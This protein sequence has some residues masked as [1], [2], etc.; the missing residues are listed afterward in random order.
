VSR[1]TP[2]SGANG[3][4]TGGRATDRSTWTALAIVYIAWGSTYV[5]IRVMDRTTPPLIGGAIRFLAAGALMFGFVVLRRRRLPRVSGRELASL[6]LVGVLLLSGGNGLVTL[7]E[8]RVPAGLAALLV[9]SMPLW[10]LVLRTLTGD[11]PRRATLV[12]LAIGFCGVGLLVLRGGRGHGV[13][14]VQMLVVVGAALSWATGSFLSSKLPL[15]ADVA[16]GTAIE[17]MIGGAV[18]A[19][20]G[21]LVGEHWQALS[22]QVSADAWIA[23][24]YLAL[25]GSI[26][27]F[28]A[29]VWLLQNAPISKISTYAY[30]NPVVAVVL[31]AVILGEAITPFMVLGGVVI[32]TAVAVVIGSESRPDPPAPAAASVELPNAGPAL[33]ETRRQRTPAVAGWR[34]PRGPVG[35]LSGSGVEHAADELGA[36][37]GD[38]H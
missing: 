8:R 18:L 21:P 33:L 30:V 6:T 20:L 26:L 16:A 11:R 29:Y 24:A 22:G 27:A 15:P 32:V 17:M 28:T 4:G 38:R 5:G 14:V 10:V 19:G 37:V 31:A 3:A 9:A 13:D 35:R 36:V 2:I 1:A 12:G 34:S 7:A 23:I 25:A